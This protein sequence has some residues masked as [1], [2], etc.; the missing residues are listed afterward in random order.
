MFFC[1]FLVLQAV[2][3]EAWGQLGRLLGTLEAPSGALRWPR[4]L[5]HRF[6]KDFGVQFGVPRH[7][8]SALVVYV[9]LS[10]CRDASGTAF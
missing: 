9:F 4:S 6:S 10:V 2:I 8:F 1:P 7:S 3:L 5:F